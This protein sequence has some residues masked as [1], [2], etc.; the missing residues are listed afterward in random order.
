MDSKIM[1]EEGFDSL[2]KPIQAW[3]YDNIG[4]VL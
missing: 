1:L 2:I 3:Y 4:M